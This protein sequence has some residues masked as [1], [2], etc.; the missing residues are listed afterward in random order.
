MFG[1]TMILV[2]S[3]IIIFNKYKK[4]NMNYKNIWMITWKSFKIEGK[5]FE[6]KV[7]KTQNNKYIFQQKIMIFQKGKIKK[8]KKFS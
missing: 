6:F 3:F 8:I 1:Y 2:S 5:S 4:I 7:L